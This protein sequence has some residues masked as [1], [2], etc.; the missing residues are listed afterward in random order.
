[1]LI[2]NSRQNIT[3]VEKNISYI[4]DPNDPNQA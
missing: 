2:T 1:M 4:F 3:I